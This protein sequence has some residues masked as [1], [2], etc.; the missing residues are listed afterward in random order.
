MCRHVY[1]Y[2]LNIHTSIH[3][4]LL[5]I[6]TQWILPDCTCFAGLQLSGVC[7]FQPVN[8]RSR[9]KPV[10]FLLAHLLVGFKY[11]FIRLCQRNDD[12]CPVELESSSEHIFTHSSHGRVLERAELGDSVAPR[13]DNFVTIAVC[14][15]AQCK[16]PSFPGVACLCI[17]YL[18]SLVAGPGLFAP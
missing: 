14:H 7:S 8:A 10:F 15:F 2:I 18:L 13:R 9:T 1:V 17:F 3:I 4:D 11:Q 5:Y 12:I 6:H 16:S